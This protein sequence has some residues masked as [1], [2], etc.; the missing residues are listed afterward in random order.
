M[1][2]PTNENM[3]EVVNRL[4]ICIKMNALKLENIYAIQKSN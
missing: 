2:F 1:I 4:K 3:N